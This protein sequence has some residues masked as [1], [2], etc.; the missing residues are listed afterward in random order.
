MPFEPEET[1]KVNGWMGSF[2]SESVPEY[3]TSGCMKFESEE[4]GKG[5]AV[6]AAVVTSP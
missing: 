5:K 6:E 3:S 1:S 2:R 4:A